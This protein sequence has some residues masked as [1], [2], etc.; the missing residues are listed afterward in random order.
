MLNNLRYDPDRH[1][2]ED[3]ANNF[4]VW[5]SN[6]CP[7]YAGGDRRI[8]FLTEGL[9]ALSQLCSMLVIEVLALKKQS[10]N[11]ALHIWMPPHA[12]DIWEKRRS[13]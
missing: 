8:K 1:S 4:L 6:N 12:R 11:N 2:L 3:M 13:Q 9:G 5:Y 10:A 7:R